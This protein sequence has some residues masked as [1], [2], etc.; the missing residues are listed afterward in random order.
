MGLGSAF[1]WVSIIEGHIWAHTI[2]MT[3]R[4]TNYTKEIEIAFCTILCYYVR[5]KC[6]KYPN[7]K[8]VDTRYY[9][10]NIASPAKCRVCKI[11]SGILIS[12]NIVCSLLQ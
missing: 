9:R 11:L 7:P 2:L 12:P 6:Y 10:I 8:L 4:L 5:F 1:E 3:A